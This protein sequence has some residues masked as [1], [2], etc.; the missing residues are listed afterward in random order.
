MRSIPDSV[1]SKTPLSGGIRGPGLESPCYPMTNAANGNGGGQF[2]STMNG[3]YANK[4]HQD[5]PLPPQS[6]TSPPVHSNYMQPNPLAQL[7]QQTEMWHN[8]QDDLRPRSSGNP[9]MMQ[10]IPPPYH[11]QP[12]PPLSIPSPLMM[13]KH[14]QTPHPMHSMNAV[15]MPMTPPHSNSNMSMTPP[16]SNENIPPDELALSAAFMK[17]SPPE[18]GC[19]EAKPSLEALQPLMENNNAQQHGEYMPMYG[20]GVQQHQQQQ[21]VQQHQQFERLEE[22]HMKR[23]A[24]TPPAAA[25]IRTAHPASPATAPAKKPSSKPL[26]DFNE[27]F[28]STER[29]RFQSPPDPRLAPHKGYLDLFYEDAHQI[30]FEDFQM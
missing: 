1:A 15:S 20:H 22:I 25:Q 5:T 19:F 21:N 16:Y 29:G 4:L 6:T 8:Y 12:S 28:G 7:Q 17:T 13:D 14:R 18:E 9:Y 30:K 11:H 26:P 27:A 23:P 3:G 24:A 10:D 2:M